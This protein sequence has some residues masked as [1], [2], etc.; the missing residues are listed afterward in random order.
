LIIAGYRDHVL[1]H[2]TAPN[3]IFKFAKE[4]KMKE[5]EFYTYFTSFES[6]KSAIWVDIFDETLAQ[7]E[8]QDVFKTYSARE[9]F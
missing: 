8:V 7:I 6:I 5:E 1:E 4:L 2:G 3:S 9:K